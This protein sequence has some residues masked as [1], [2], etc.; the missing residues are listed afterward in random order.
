MLLNLE[1]NEFRRSST[2]ATSSE[3][4]VPL[5]EDIYAGEI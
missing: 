4:S 1:V 5:E 2:T 3:G